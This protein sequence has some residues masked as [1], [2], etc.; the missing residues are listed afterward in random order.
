MEVQ[1]KAKG[2]QSTCMGIVEN[3]RKLWKVLLA[4]IWNAVNLL[5]SRDLACVQM[6]AF[7]SDEGWAVVEISPEKGVRR[8]A[9][10]GQIRAAPRFVGLYVP[11]GTSAPEMLIMFHVEH[12]FLQER[13][14]SGPPDGS[15]SR[16]SGDSAARL[17]GAWNSSS[18]G[19]ILKAR[20]SSEVRRGLGPP[21]DEAPSGS[22]IGMRELYGRASS[23]CG[24]EAWTTSLVSPHQPSRRS[25]SVPGE[26][27]RQC[28]P[29][30][31]AVAA[32]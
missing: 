23:A 30:W 15:L 9:D 6:E 31:I 3:L 18:Q 29:K 14:L 24:D 19:H 32:S 25:G 10:G 1:S 28:S 26:A 22:R 20:S 4:V 21:A 16:Q 8:G 2:A 27:Q 12:S 11:R 13:W 17:D 5:F 7:R